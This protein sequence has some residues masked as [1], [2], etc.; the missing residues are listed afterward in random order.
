MTD[1]PP[2][3]DP[4]VVFA[5]KSTSAAKH[6][7]NPGAWE[8]IIAWTKS[9]GF[10][11]ICIDQKRRL[12][13]GFLSY[14]FPEGAED[15]TGDRP[16]TERARWIRHAAAFVGLSSGLSWLAWH[17]GTPTVLISGMTAPFN[18]FETP[19]RVINFN[20]CNSCWNDVN[21]RFSHEDFMWCP[22]HAGTKRQFECTGL[23]TAEHV[24]RKLK[25]ALNV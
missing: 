25:E 24:I 23:I 22:R 21:E 6:L 8:D 16:L 15:E 13:G 12:T 18:E 5:T 19:G 17:L 1:R 14:P 7:N 10:R 4:Y 2:I 20:A 11:A 3:A 9:Q